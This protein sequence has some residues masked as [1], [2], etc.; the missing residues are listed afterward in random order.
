MWV[1]EARMSVDFCDDTVDHVA[2][3]LTAQL[4]RDNFHRHLGSTVR[5]ALDVRSRHAGSGERQHA[6]FITYCPIHVAKAAASKEGLDIKSVG[7]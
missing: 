3:M 7:L 4:L 6:R 2:T 5:Q 1:L